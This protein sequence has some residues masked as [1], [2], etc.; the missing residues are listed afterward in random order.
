MTIIW[1]PEAPNSHQMGVARGMA[2]G[3]TRILIFEVI[4]GLLSLLTKFCTASFYHIRCIHPDRILVHPKL[5]S[6]QTAAASDFISALSLFLFLLFPIM[7][8]FRESQCR[9]KNDVL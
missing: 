9:D 2:V 4:F 1:R 6:Q 7:P 5:V 8:E 3:L